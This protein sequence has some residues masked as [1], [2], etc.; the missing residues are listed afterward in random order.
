MSDFQKSLFADEI[1]QARER[2]HETIITRNG[3]R[4]WRKG[5][6]AGRSPPSLKGATIA[7]QMRDTAIVLLLAAVGI[8]GYFVRSMNTTLTDQQRQISNLGVVNK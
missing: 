4:R 6:Y 3:L 1:V 5:A 8:L 7:P 2:I